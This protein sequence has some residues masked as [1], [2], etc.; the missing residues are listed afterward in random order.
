MLASTFALLWFQPAGESVMTQPSVPTHFSLF[1]TP[2]SSVWYQFGRHSL[3]LVPVCIITGLSLPAER[4]RQCP[5]SYCLQ[6]GIP[7]EAFSIGQKFFLIFFIRD[8]VKLDAFPVDKMFTHT[9]G[10]MEVS[11]V[12][13]F[14]W[15]GT[16]KI[17]LNDAEW[18]GR[19]GDEIWYVG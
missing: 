10:L 4:E 3:P 19:D 15:A 1:M 16:E 5:D 13:M 18:T 2:R 8:N 14:G 9:R 7:T 17:C 11:N 6:L 12:A